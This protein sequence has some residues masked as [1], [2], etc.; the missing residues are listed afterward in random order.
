[1]SRSLGRMTHLQSCTNMLELKMKR[2]EA[3]EEGKPVV[4]LCGYMTTSL[5]MCA[6]HWPH[7]FV[8]VCRTLTTF[9]S[10]CLIRNQDKI[11]NRLL[12]VLTGL[13]QTTALL[14]L[15]SYWT[16]G[17]QTHWF[18]NLPKQRNSC[19]LRKEAEKVFPDWS[20]WLM[21]RKWWLQ[22]FASQTEPITFSESRW[23]KVPPWFCVV[24][25]GLWAQHDTVSLGSL[26][27]LFIFETQYIHSMMCQWVSFR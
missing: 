5:L 27:V 26:I 1:M 13:S 6:A 8:D 10:L 11:A 15:F 25:H 16:P 18:W 7:L 24:F 12:E 21:F 9:K 19:L 14:A 2:D 22:L 4:F 23:T 3:E 17:P 20:K